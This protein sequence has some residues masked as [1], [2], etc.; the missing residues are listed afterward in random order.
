MGIEPTENLLAARFNFSNTKSKNVSRETEFY[1]IFYIKCN[2]G[3]K[4]Y[5]SFVILPNEEDSI[6]PTPPNPILIQTHKFFNSHNS[7]THFNT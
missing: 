2:R 3:Y 1:T 5:H 7:F 4:F 6:I